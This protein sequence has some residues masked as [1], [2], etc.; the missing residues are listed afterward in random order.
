[1]QRCLV[2]LKKP[3]HDQQ[4]YVFR[5]YVRIF[6]GNTEAQSELIPKILEVIDKSSEDL[7]VE[8]GLAFNNMLRDM[9]VEEDYLIKHI[10]FTASKVLSTWSQEVLFEWRQVFKL[11][12]RVL[13]PQ[14]T[15]DSI[16]RGMKLCDKTQ[17]M[18][19]RLNGAYLLG[20]MVKYF[21]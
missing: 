8:A 10:H 14:E 9:I 5:N 4:S 17:P 15:R 11:S 7:Q 12:M 20:K 21:E 3:E 2:L 6:K 18:V 19:T 13:S 1:M 16:E